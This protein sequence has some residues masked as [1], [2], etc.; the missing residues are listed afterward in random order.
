MNKNN[1]IQD[2]LRLDKETKFT[3]KGI[4]TYRS[5]DNGEYGSYVDDALIR[6]Y[7]STKEKQA[8]NRRI[9]IVFSPS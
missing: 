5:D 1:I 7:N 2:Q 3:V 8:Q 4:T 6:E 9:K